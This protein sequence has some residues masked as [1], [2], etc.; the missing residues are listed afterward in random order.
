MAQSGDSWLISV[1]CYLALNGW[2]R[3]GFVIQAMKTRVSPG[4]TISQLQ[5]PGTMWPLPGKGLGEGR[6]HGSSPV[7]DGLP[8]PNDAIFSR[9]PACLELEFSLHLK[10]KSQ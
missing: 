6:Q 3:D 9:D 4:K 8:D 10:C 7:M 5:L 1:L 2:F